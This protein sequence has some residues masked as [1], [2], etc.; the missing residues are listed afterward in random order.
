MIELKRGDTVVLICL[1]ADAYNNKLGKVVRLLDGATGRCGTSVYLPIDPHLPAELEEGRIG[2]R[3][4]ARA[5][6]G[7]VRLPIRQRAWMRGAD[8]AVLG[9]V[10]AGALC[11]RGLT[12][13][14]K[15]A[16]R[17]LRRDGAGQ[18]WGCSTRAMR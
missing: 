13:E 3:E 16:A 9:L 11:E 4:A 17:S 5:G 8:H 10:D 18:R 2:T 7:R 14:K 1:R 15:D 12:P 6:E